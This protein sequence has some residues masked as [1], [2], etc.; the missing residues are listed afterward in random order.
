MEHARDRGPLPLH[1]RDQVLH[2]PLHGPVARNAPDHPRGLERSL[3][4]PT[5]HKFGPC[6]GPRADVGHAALVPYDD[7]DDDDDLGGSSHVHQPRMPEAGQPEQL[8]LALLEDL[9]TVL[10]AHGYPPLRGYALAELA[11]SLY[12]IGRS[13]P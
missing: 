3:A 9:A 2:G 4:A 6:G 5:L 1:K 12:R 13:S 10:H 11:S 7:F 8:T